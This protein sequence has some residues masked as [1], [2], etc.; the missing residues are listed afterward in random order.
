MPPIK[1]VVVDDDPLILKMIALYLADDRF[2]LTTVPESITAFDQILEKKPDLVLIDLIMPQVDGLKLCKQIKSHDELTHTKFIMISAK[3]YEFDEKRSYEFGADGYLIKPFQPEQLLNKIDAVM[4]DKIAMTFWGVRGTLPVPGPKSLKYGGNTSC[5]SLEFPRKQFFIFDAGSG[6]K[7]LGNSLI[8][9]GL[10]RLKAKI[11][12]SHP[13]WDHINAIPFFAPLYT[14]GSDIEFLGANQGDVTMYELISAQMDGVYFPITLSEFAARVYFRDLE[15]ETIDVD[16]IEVKTQLLSHPGK[17]LGY[18]VN[19]QGRSICYITDNEF[20]P[21]DNESYN[22]H[23]EKRLAE[24]CEGADA[25]ISDC[26]YTDE[27]YK[28]HIG[29]GHSSVS[30]VA[31]FAHTANVKMLYLFHHDPDQDDNDIDNK[32]LE[33]E[34]VLDGL[35]SSTTVIAPKEGDQFKI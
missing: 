10:K 27:S 13:H 22:A 23:Y 24:F 34:A 11:F 17:C 6:I 3:T 12:I 9:R 25:L 21:R 14:Q 35:S 4:E 33:A 7:N 15:G 5:V 28:S 18:R 16:G 8:E 20:F 32:L 31:E 19:Y 29:W 1:V 2:D 30:R 26:T